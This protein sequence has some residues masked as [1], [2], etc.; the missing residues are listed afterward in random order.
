MGAGFLEPSIADLDLTTH[1]YR[2][3]LDLRYSPVIGSIISRKAASID[4]LLDVVESQL[5]CLG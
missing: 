3:R 5:S 2:F 4:L 1:R